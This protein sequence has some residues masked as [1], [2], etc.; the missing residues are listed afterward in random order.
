MIKKLASVFYTL[1]I[2]IDS[3]SHTNA[4]TALSWQKGWGGLEV[5]RDFMP[6]EVEPLV[7]IAADGQY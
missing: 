6:F 3:I 4:Q 7:P 1:K 2:I 5:A